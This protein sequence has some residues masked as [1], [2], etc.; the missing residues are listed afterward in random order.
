M[1]DPKS[2]AP[3]ACLPLMEEIAPAA[4]TAPTAFMLPAS[5]PAKLLNAEQIDEVQTWF[6][7]FITDLLHRVRCALCGHDSDADTSTLTHLQQRAVILAHLLRLHPAAEASLT[8]L[9]SALGVSRRTAFYMQDSIL[10]HIKPALAGANAKAV[11][12]AHFATQLATLGTLLP[13][14]ATY[15]SAR[16]LYVPFKPHVH[17]A[18]RFATVQSVAA[19]PAVAAVREDFL[20]NTNKNAIR[21][22]LK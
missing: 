17:V 9:A 20:P 3:Y 21:I 10:S 14:A 2:V 18:H 4:D 11:A 19:L 16:Q 1:A 5:F 7:S 12:L 13:D 8:H 6:D 15:T 22:T